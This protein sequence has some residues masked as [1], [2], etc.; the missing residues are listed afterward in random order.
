MFSKTFSTFCKGLIF[1]T[2]PSTSTRFLWFFLFFFDRNL[3]IKRKSVRKWLSNRQIRDVFR[4]TSQHLENVTFVNFYR[5][6]NWIRFSDVWGQTR[7]FKKESWEKAQSVKTIFIY[8]NVFFFSF[9]ITMQSR[10]SKLRA[11][12]RKSIQLFK[13]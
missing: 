7:F 4:F 8:R 11:K 9:F 3:K 5:F 1:N 12:C 6:R 2:E 10:K 13:R